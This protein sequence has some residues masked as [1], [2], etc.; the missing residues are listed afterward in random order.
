MAFIYDPSTPDNRSPEEKIL[1]VNNRLAEL[2]RLR[3]QEVQLVQTHL[4]QLRGRRARVHPE[5][6]PERERERVC[7]RLEREN[8][9]TQRQATA[10]T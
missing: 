4:G 6:V 5:L 1:D 3:K 2:P 9:R 10:K 7:P 8:S